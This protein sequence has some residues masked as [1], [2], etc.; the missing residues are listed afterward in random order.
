MEPKRW[1]PVQPRLPYQQVAIGVTPCWGG[2]HPTIDL[3]RPPYQQAAI[4]VP[5]RLRRGLPHFSVCHLHRG[6]VSPPP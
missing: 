2:G 6:H 1:A 5:P 3:P 4:R